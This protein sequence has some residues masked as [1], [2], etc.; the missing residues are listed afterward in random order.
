MSAV[1]TRGVIDLAHEPSFVQDRVA[2]SVA[3]VIEPALQTLETRRAVLCPTDN[4]GSYDLWLR[5]RSLSSTHGKTEVFEALALLNRAIALDPRFALALSTAAW[6]HSF[7]LI[8]SW[9]DDSKVHRREGVALA[10]RSLRVGGDDPDVLTN[11][12]VALWQL[13]EG[14]QP[15]LALIDRA[16]DLNPGSAST[17]YLSGVLRLAAGEPEIV[18]EHIQLSV[19]LD[20][21]SP[22]NSGRSFPLGAARFLQSRFV[23]AVVHLT[24]AAQSFE[25]P[26]VFVFLA[27]S[28]GHLGRA[29]EARDALARYRT[30]SRT[31]ISAV[32]A[33]FPKPEHRKLFLDGIALAEGR[34]PADSSACGAQPG[35]R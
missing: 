19:R 5:A 20:P 22:N 10:H 28:F 2:L 32:A 6:C 34:S 30:L 25:L 4:I 21:W 13:G 3:G 17:W 27:A 14:V 15:W 31:P 11:T 16:I 8:N 23:E 35:A 12:A 7:I 26:F 33:M 1:E 9:S 29:S 24:E 18:I